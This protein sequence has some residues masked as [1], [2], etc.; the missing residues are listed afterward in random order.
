MQ[1]YTSPGRFRAMTVVLMLAPGTPLLFMGQE[2]ASSKPFLYFADHEE[3]LAHLIREGR[4]AS[5]HQFRCLRAPEM[6]LFFADPCIAETFAACKLDWNERESQS[7]AFVFHRDLIRLRK[8]DPV[9]SAQ[10][11]ANIHGT[12]LS[13][14]A[15]ALRYVGLHGEDRLVV[16]N[17]GRDLVWTS[18]AYPLLAP[19]QETQWKLLLSTSDPKYGGAGVAEI[20]DHEWHMPGHAALV[21]RPEPKV[22]EPHEALTGWPEKRDAPPACATASN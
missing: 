11:A 13:A 5:L 2:F 20:D 4:L 19:P 16:V 12:M 1:F 22:V 6:K 9:F 15:F 3:G 8:S 7:E 21:L 14:E 18:S 17:L 10:Q